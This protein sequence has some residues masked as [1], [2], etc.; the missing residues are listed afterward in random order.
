MRLVFTA[1][2]GTYVGLVNVNNTII[3]TV[4]PGPVHVHLLVEN[5]LDGEQY[6]LVP[7]GHWEI[8]FSGHV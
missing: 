8:L 5:M 1:D 4:C 2:D 6:L 3:D 7:G